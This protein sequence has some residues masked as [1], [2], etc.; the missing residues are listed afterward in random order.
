MAT[1]AEKLEEA[2]NALHMLMTGTKVVRVS[3]AS[4]GG[5]SRSVDYT[6][7]NVTELRAYIRELEAEC[8]G[9]GGP[10]PRRPFGVTW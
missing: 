10:R 4:A 7:A 1:C 9:D 5:G 8:G 6:Q 2:R 3:Y